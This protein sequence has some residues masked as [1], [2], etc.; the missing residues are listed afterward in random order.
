MGKNAKPKKPAEKQHKTVKTKEEEKTKKKP[1]QRKNTEKPKD[2]PTK[3]P[4][5]PAKK[6]A[7]KPAKQG[8]ENSEYK[9]KPGQKHQEPSFDDP[10]RAFYE[11]LYEQNPN[12]EMAQRYCVA[13]GLLPKDTA[14]QL[15]NKF[16][17][18]R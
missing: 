1:I 7:R 15:F 14:E 10:S 2:P 6:P 17:K 18:K 9:K 5:A 13:Y 12:S 4:K 16:S 11:S 3:T 8:E